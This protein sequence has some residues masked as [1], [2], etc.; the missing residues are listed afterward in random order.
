MIESAVGATSHLVLTHR[1]G[2]P[3]SR[4]LHVR[5]P[6][7]FD[8]LRLGLLPVFGLLLAGCLL[9]SP[10]SAHAQFPEGANKW[11]EIDVTNAINRAID[12]SN[13]GADL[14]EKLVRRFSEC[15]LMY[16][17]L[18]TLTS[19]AEAKKDYVQAQ[20]ATM[21]IELTVAKPLQSEKRLEIE[22]SARRSVAMML[23]ALKAQNDHKEVGPL[24]KSCKSL[25][26]T[27]EINNA[28]REILRQ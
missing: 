17:G 21:E 9:I 28:V 4:A 19:N 13:P 24:L 27:R 3:F 20:L 25:N 18:S 2:P 26:D 10:R 22:E 7:M 11:A 14:R 8:S 16:G 12:E 1:S 15:S 5:E 23:R 6:V